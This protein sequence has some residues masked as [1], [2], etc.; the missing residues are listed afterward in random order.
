MARIFNHPSG[1]DYL[2]STGGTR[3]WWSA[4][5]TIFALMNTFW[6]SGDGAGHMVIYIK[7]TAGTNNFTYVKHTDNNLYVGWTTGG[8][9]ARIAL[10]D[11]GLFTAFTAL[12]T[13]IV[14]WDDTAN[15]QHLYLD[16]VLVGTSTLAFTVPVGNADSYVLGSTGSATPW[17][18]AIAELARWN[19]VLTAA[20]RAV[21]EATRCPLFVPQ[22]LVSYLPLIGRTSPEVELINGENLAVNGSPPAA[23]HARVRYPASPYAMALPVAAPVTIPTITPPLVSNAFQVFAPSVSV[24]GT[25]GPLFP[26]LVSN[27]FQVFAPT[28]SVGAFAHE[29]GRS[30]F[31]F[32]FVDEESNLLVAAN[33]ASAAL[34]SAIDAATEPPFTITLS[35]DLSR[36]ADSGALTVD[37]REPTIG[38]SSEIFYFDGKSGDELT[39]TA[40]AQDG[41]TAK[42]FAAGAQAQMRNIARH[43]NLLAETIIDI[44]EAVLANEANIGAKADAVHTHAIADVTGLQA[45]LDSM[46]DV[47]ALDTRVSKS[48]DTMSGLLTLFGAPTADL[49]AA[50]KRYVD[51]IASTVYNVKS[52]G[53]VGDGTTDDTA[54]AVA[55][56]AEMVNVKKGGKL[57]WPKG[58]YLIGGPLLDTSGANAQIPI[59][60]VDDSDPAVTIDMV[61]HCAPNLAWYFS[62][63][64]PTGDDYSIIR[65]TLTGAS[66]TA[67]L[68]RSKMPATATQWNNLMVNFKDL[69]IRAPANPS[70]TA[71]DMQTAVGNRM[72]STFIYAGLPTGTPTEPTVATATAVKCPQVN[73]SAYIR[74]EGLTV[75]GFYRGIQIGELTTGKVIVYGCQTAIF[76]PFSYHASA[77]DYIGAYDCKYGIVAAGAGTTGVA[78]DD[79]THY[80][81]IN[82][83]DFQN[84]NGMCLPWQDHV[85]HVYDP[86]NLLHGSVNWLGIDSGAGRTHTFVKNGGTSLLTKEVGAV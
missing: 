62:S 2:G 42:S 7:N 45:E 19:R 31:P 73:H 49:H 18:G 70:F 41:T 9:D 23:G 68:F 20:E 72:E 36:F 4:N 76:V 39:I 3:P 47:T 69:I 77:F 14:D 38:T 12:H 80:L 26:P 32:G 79:G 48:G 13:H 78:G 84:A 50:T 82:L 21:L 52:F 54:A 64:N 30:S 33:N 67:A 85:A 61:G 11:A 58:I 44:E 60:G 46:L 34:G 8:V 10:A 63:V 5:G 65:S 27:P 25:A 75:L 59:P 53:L 81:V 56:M 24:E 57:Y 6:A 83:Y 16:N 55:M 22:G 40:R 29:V 86:S 74:C 37:V 71:I 66:G 35:G 28:V 15:L 43:H 51:S 17:G 1:I